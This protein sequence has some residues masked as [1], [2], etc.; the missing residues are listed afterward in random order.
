MN[1]FNDFHEF[2]WR[3]QTS[4]FTDLENLFCVAKKLLVYWSYLFDFHLRLILLYSIKLGPANSI[5]R[6][7]QI[8]LFRH[9]SL[10]V[11]KDSMHD[12]IQ[13]LSDKEFDFLTIVF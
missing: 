6:L 12:G 2:F 5:I 9:N 7:L 4:R 13:D 3:I 8:S 1:W 10:L 11:L